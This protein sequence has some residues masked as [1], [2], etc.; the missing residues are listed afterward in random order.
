MDFNELEGMINMLV[1]ISNHLQVAEEGMQEMR[2][3]RTSHT[4]P[5]PF[6]QYAREM[7]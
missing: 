6:Y 1:D 5:E 4:H 7:C 2:F 3:R